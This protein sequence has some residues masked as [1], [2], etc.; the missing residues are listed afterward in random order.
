[1]SPDTMTAFWL[2]PAP[3]ERE[4]FRRMIADL[5]RSHAAPV[6]LPHVTIGGGEV[7]ARKT[8]ALLDR[9]RLQVLE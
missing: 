6:F 4:F 3:E 7:E 8:E 9:V 2:V 5:A 1:M